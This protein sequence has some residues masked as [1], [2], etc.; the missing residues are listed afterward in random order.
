M[1][2]VIPILHVIC[3]IAVLIFPCKCI[4][5]KMKGDFGEYLKQKVICFLNISQS[6]VSEVSSLL[7]GYNTQHSDHIL[8]ENIQN[9]LMFKP[10]P[11]VELELLVKYYA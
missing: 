7:K 5:L 6:I 3:S 2:T 8:V 4:N 1:C 9:E 11:R 10:I